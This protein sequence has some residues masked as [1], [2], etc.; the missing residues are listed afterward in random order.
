MTKRTAGIVDAAAYGFSYHKF[1]KFHLKFNQSCDTLIK[2]I[3][4]LNTDT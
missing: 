4:T 3:E 1:V 2:K